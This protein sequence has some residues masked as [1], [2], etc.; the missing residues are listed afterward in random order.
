MNAETL[1]VLQDLGFREDE[2]DRVLNVTDF[3]RDDPAVRCRVSLPHA[4]MPHEI[5]PLLIEEGRRQL[6]A[7]IRR[8]RK[9][10]EELTK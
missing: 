5:V 2:T 4:A 1:T 6:S 7:E 10:L 9:K 3:V 8:A